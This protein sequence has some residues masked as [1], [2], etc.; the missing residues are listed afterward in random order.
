MAGR[1]LDEMLD[2]LLNNLRL[3]DTAFDDVQRGL[4]TFA[5]P[6]LEQ[7]VQ[8]ES[9][10]ELLRLRQARS[11]LQLAMVQ[12]KNKEIDKAESTYLRS[13]D[14]MKKL[15]PSAT[16]S[17]GILLKGLS[18]AHLEYGR[19]INMFRNNPDLAE[20][21]YRLSLEYINQLDHGTN[22]PK[23][24]D[25]YAIHYSLLASLLTELP[26][27]KEEGLS[28]SLKAIDYRTRLMEMNPERDDLRHYAALTHLNLAIF[29][30]K[31]KL[32]AKEIEQLSQALEL[33]KQ[34]NRSKLVWIES[35]YFVST[36]QG[37]LGMAYYLNKQPEV[38]RPYFVE[39]SRTAEALC[40]VYPSVEKYEKLNKQWKR[41]L[42][43]ID[44]KK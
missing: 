2:R 41:I 16:L 40:V 3:Q 17:N 44:K 39:A 27:R 22:A 10:G 14:L 12:V 4:V 37:E 7:F 9:S 28:Y 13:L 36:L 32:N 24:F 1:V 15:Q 20:K 19:F 6:Y 29:Y 23:Y 25:T 21:H 35:P 11:L 31:Q 34:V 38:A 18:S 5:I 33:E 30:R 8:E 42:A 43:F 26:E